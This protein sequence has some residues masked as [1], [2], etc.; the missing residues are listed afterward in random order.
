MTQK[1]RMEKGLVY[2]CNDESILSDQALCLEKQY[3]YNKSNRFSTFRY[4][5][6]DAGCFSTKILY[7]IFRLLI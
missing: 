7:T 6:S 2:Y 5:F 1:E 3:D 4:K